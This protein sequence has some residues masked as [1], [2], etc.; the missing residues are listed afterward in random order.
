M[1]KKTILLFSLLL[2]VIIVIIVIVI[3][4]IR[5]DKFSIKNESSIKLFHWNIHYSCF[6]DYNGNC[7]FRIRDTTHKK[8]N[9]KQFIMEKYFKDIDF[10]NLI[11]FEEDKIVDKKFKKFKLLSPKIQTIN[12]FGNNCEYSS[13]IQKCGKHDNPLNLVYNSNKW[14]YIQSMNGCIISNSSYTTDDSRPF[15]IG[16]FKSKKDSNI[17]IFVICIYMQH[18][19]DLDP[20][21]TIEQLNNSLS[22]SN[23]NFNSKTDKLIFMSDTN[24]LG[25]EDNAQV[26]K[27]INNRS[28]NISQQQY[29]L[30]E[31]IASKLTE[32]PI[33]EQYF[34]PSK[35]KTCCNDNTGFKYD[36][37]RIFTNFGKRSLITII[38]N[39][40]L[41]KPIKVKNPDTELKVP[42]TN[43]MH[44]PLLL[45]V[46]Y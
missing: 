45:E 44:R 39:K 19:W 46:Y 42:Y 35:I 27:D 43:E 29:F 40:E 2:I 15:I 34:T 41:E 11:M 25:S 17:I 18:P 30:N 4:C 16:K 13:L 14:I 22:N 21:K 12:C 8:Q 31:F 38:P 1:N 24:L 10:A 23:L 28:D 5:R 6:T 36:Y 3:F 26:F 20:T 32:K 7:D 33:T 37:D 9:I